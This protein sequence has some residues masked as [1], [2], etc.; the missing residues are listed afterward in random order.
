MSSL[1]DNVMSASRF[2]HIALIALG[3]AMF[4]C[5]GTR[6]SNLGIT[7]GRLRPCPTSPN[8]V[9]SEAG[10]ADAWL[11]T[12]LRS[13]G[14]ADMSRLAGLLRTWPRAMVVT[15]TDSYIHAEFTSRLMRYVDDVEFRY[16][17]AAHAIQVRSAS[18]LGRSDLG[19]NRK[20]V[21]AI[22]EKWESEK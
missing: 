21:D 3:V 22:R 1:G 19:V 2:R 9:S 4:G 16:D 7:A 17:S 5:T 10:T 18:R 15:A 8:C 12:P 20:R 13:A 14:T 11:T 6:P